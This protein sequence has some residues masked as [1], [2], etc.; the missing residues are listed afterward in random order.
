MAPV[1][2]LLSLAVFAVAGSL[3]SA[4]VANAP[5]P[6]AYIHEERVFAPMPTMASAPEREQAR[7]A[8][9]VD[10]LGDI[11]S[12]FGDVTSGAASLFSV[13]TSGAVSVGT[14]I[15]TGAV[16]EFS[17]VSYVLLMRKNHG[18]AFYELRAGKK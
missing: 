2:A 5:S 8:R 11:T 12:A 1:K 10:L 16:S 15:A 7:A 18:L 6:T 17:K 3:A 14:A 13:A 9:D 4:E